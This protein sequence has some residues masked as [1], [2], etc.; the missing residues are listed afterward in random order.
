MTGRAQSVYAGQSNAE[1]PRGSTLK[2]KTGF[3]QRAQ[4]VCQSF[5][6]GA[7]RPLVK[8]NFQPVLTRSSNMR[9]TIVRAPSM[10]SSS[11]P[12]DSTPGS[13]SSSVGSPTLALSEEIR[14]P[15]GSHHSSHEAGGGE[16]VTSR[17]SA[18]VKPDPEDAKR[19][20]IIP[21]L[22]NRR[23]APSSSDSVGR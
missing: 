7:A 4:R 1:D 14:I 6:C 23:K 2:T 21:G 13:P 11:S 19:Y 5:A 22:R 16:P 15:T 17:M 18:N 20:R 12:A 3:I 9:S 10:R 8:D